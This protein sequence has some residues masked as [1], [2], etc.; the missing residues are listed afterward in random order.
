MD[1]DQK[2]AKQLGA[3]VTPEAII[4][5]D[6][7]EVIYRGRISDTYQAIGRRKHSAGR[8]DL[9]VA[10]YQALNDKP[11]DKPWPKAIGCL[12]TYKKSEK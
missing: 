10:I 3:K 8:K 1:K 2:I 12:V 11:I 9:R 4:L 5:N 7:G 6:L